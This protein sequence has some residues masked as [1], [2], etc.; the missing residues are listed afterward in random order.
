M[1][2]KLLEKEKHGEID[3]F[4]FDESGFNLQACV[5]YAWQEKKKYIKVP[6]SRSKNLNV[7]GFINHDCQFESVVFEETVNTDVVVACFDNFANKI[8][9]PTYVLIDN[10]PTH[11]SD[12][13]LAH[14]A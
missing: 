13:F 4:Y 2:A 7:L 10:A 9:K 3:V 11:T 1:I 12:Y 8:E 6:S 5:P 14:F